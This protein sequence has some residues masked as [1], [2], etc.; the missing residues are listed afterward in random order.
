MYSGGQSVKGLAGEVQQI[1]HN[2]G[3]EIMEISRQ[4]TSIVSRLI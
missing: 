2:N 1:E 3:E 4:R